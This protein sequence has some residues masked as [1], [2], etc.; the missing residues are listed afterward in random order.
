MISKLHHAIAAILALPAVRDNL[1]A[2][3]ITVAPPQAPASFA[4]LIRSELTKWPA[5]IKASGAK[6]D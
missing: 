6:A 3:G 5:V 1:A 2:Q 4:A